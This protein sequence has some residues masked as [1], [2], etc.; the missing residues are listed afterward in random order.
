MFCDTYKTN[1]SLTREEDE[2]VEIFDAI[3]VVFL[4]FK[5]GNLQDTAVTILLAMFPKSRQAKMI[6]QFRVDNSHLYSTVKAR[7]GWI[8]LLKLEKGNTKS[9]RNF[10]MLSKEAISYLLF[11]SYS[12]YL[13]KSDIAVQPS[14]YSI[15][16]QQ[17]VLKNRENTNGKTYR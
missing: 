16:S 6:R 4:A 11:I 7:G 1:L 9:R 2:T 14:S 8:S 5:F 10:K 15:L 12:D 13:S 17:E 3:L